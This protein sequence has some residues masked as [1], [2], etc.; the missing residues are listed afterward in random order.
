[1]PHCEAWAFIGV[2]WGIVEQGSDY[3]GTGITLTARG[4]RLLVARGRTGQKWRSE[5]G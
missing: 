4:R 2:K 3:V 5:G 1:M